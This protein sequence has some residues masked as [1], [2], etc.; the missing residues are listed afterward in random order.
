MRPKKAK[1]KKRKARPVISTERNF[2]CGYCITPAA[3]STEVKGN[4][5]GNRAPESIVRIP[6]FSKD[7]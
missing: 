4:G 2:L 5:G 7:L 1:A 3:I 6:R